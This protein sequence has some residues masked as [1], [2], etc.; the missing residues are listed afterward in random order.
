MRKRPTKL[1]KM[2]QKG[3]YRAQWSAPP[4]T[5][6]QRPRKVG[7]KLKLK[8]LGKKKPKLKKKQQYVPSANHWLASAAASCSRFFSTIWCW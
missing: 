3:P 6:K 4:H 7:G 1:K 2:K 5:K 8:S